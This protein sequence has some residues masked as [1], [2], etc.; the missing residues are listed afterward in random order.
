MLMFIEAPSSD[1]YNGKS[2]R[3][4]HAG[5]NKKNNNAAISGERGLPYPQASF[6]N[7]TSLPPALLSLSED[8]CLLEQADSMLLTVGG[9]DSKKEY[10]LREG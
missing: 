3:I 2:I 10:C 1:M 8:T 6:F 7:T 5:L 9:D 4:L